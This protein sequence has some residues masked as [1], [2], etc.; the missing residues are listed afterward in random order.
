VCSKV[1]AHMATAAQSDRSSSRSAARSAGRSAAR[2]AGSGDAAAPK[3]TEAEKLEAENSNGDWSRN[4]IFDH[5][6][7][8][9]KTLPSVVA[10]GKDKKRFSL[11]KSLDRTIWPSPQWDAPNPLM[12]GAVPILQAGAEAHGITLTRPSEPMHMHNGDRCRV[13]D[14]AVF[15]FSL[16]RPTDPSRPNTQGS[17]C[18]PH[19]NGRLAP[20][21][22][23]AN[24]ATCEDFGTRTYELER[25]YICREPADKCPRPRDSAVC[26]SV[27]L[28]VCLS[29]CLSVCV[30]VCLCV[31]LSVCLCVCLCVCLPV[32]SCVCLTHVDTHKVHM[33]KITQVH[34]HKT[35]K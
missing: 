1:P 9:I 31:C 13:W 18:C 22:Y 28:C 25:E 26:L 34:M 10:A 8:K 12:D 29:V 2:S 6:R 5:M 14:P 33:Y 11:S 17:F 27:C 15:Y 32:Y 24:V 30:S 7:E 23:R 16:T 35:N 4:Y 3:A 21:G 19:C 20:N